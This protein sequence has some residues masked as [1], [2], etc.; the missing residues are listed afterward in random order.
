MTSLDY[1]PSCSRLYTSTQLLWPLLWFRQVPKGWSR[2]FGD[3]DYIQEVGPGCYEYG[4]PLSLPLLVSDGRSGRCGTEFL[5]KCGEDFY[6]Y[7]GISDNLVYI[8][9]LIALH[10]ILRVISIEPLVCLK[11]TSV[12]P[13]HGGPNVDADSHV[14]EGWTKIIDREVRKVSSRDSF[15]GHGHSAAT[16]LLRN[17]SLNG[18]T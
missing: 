8:D 6:L 17:G 18:T 9:E 7:Y 16:L 4:L 14:P 11:T 15:Q 13:E 12:D 3:L 2:S 5:I 10:D 1:R